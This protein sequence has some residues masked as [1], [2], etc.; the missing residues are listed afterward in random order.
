MAQK[1][2]PFCHKKIDSDCKKCPYCGHL[3]TEDISL[4]QAFNRPIEQVTATP[5]EQVT[6]IRAKNKRAEHPKFI[7]YFIVLLIV[8]FVLFALSRNKQLYNEDNSAKTTGVNNSVENA[9]YYNS[10]PNGTII[11]SL[12]YYLAGKGRLKIDNGTNYDAVVKLVINNNNKAIIEVYVEAGDSYTIDNIL[13]GK[14]ML[15]FMQGKNWSDEQQRFVL[16]RNCSKFV[17]VFDFVTKWTEQDDGILYEYPG[18]RVTL[19]P[20]YGGNAQTDNISEE[21]FDKY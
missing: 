13:D 19:N 1:S 20:V 17:D 14:Y 7:N 5:V 4:N 2:C 18:Y 21:E 10:L 12:P 6:N 16:D 15:L 9:K 8:F 3:L 11:Y